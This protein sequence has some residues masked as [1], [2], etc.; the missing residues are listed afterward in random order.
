ML[1]LPWAM[2]TEHTFCKES[3]R[4]QELCLNLFTHGYIPPHP[5]DPEVT[6]SPCRCCITPR[7]PALQFH[8]CSFAPPGKDIGHRMLIHSWDWQIKFFSESVQCKFF[9]WPLN[10]NMLE[11][12][13]SWKHFS[14]PTTHTLVIP[15]LAQGVLPGWCWHCFPALL[16]AVHVF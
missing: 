6:G 10:L 12:P 13:N 8:P 5:G 15:A 1:R 4:E 7:F 11:N 14:P 9:A 16:K 3:C 2:H